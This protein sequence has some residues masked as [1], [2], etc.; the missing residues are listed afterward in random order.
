MVL[1][2]CTVS[3]Q[4]PVEAWNMESV[5]SGFWWTI[6][7][8]TINKLMRLHNSHP[9]VSMPSIHKKMNPRNMEDAHNLLYMNNNK[10]RLVCNFWRL[11]AL[12]IF[13][14]CVM[15]KP[16]YVH[17]RSITRLFNTRNVILIM[18]LVWM[19]TLLDQFFFLWIIRD[20]KKCKWNVGKSNVNYYMKSLCWL[21]WHKINLHSD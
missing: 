16:L 9:V 12:N 14:L 10:K 17:S 21:C 3:L 11:E 20:V 7:G 4:D 19:A 18:K 6:S 15:V 8:C 5:F 2:R 1:E 13:C